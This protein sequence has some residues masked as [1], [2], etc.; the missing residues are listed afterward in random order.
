MLNTGG[1]SAST[2]SKSDNVSNGRPSANAAHPSMSAT[3][4]RGSK[5]N[6]ACSGRK[7]TLMRSAKPMTVPSRCATC[8]V[9]CSIGGRSGGAIVLYENP[10]LDAAMSPKLPMTRNSWRSPRW[11]EP[12]I[13]TNW[14]PDLIVSAETVMGPAGPGAR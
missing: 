9:H 12:L 10:P 11:I 3:P 2:T 14:R 13:V 4:G 6:G 7:N 1:G 5:R 8:L